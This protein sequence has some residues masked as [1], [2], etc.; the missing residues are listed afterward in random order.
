MLALL[1]ARTHSEPRFGDLGHGTSVAKIIQERK[2][3]CTHVGYCQEK[4]GCQGIVYSVDTSGNQKKHLPAESQVEG[5]SR[6][7]AVELGPEHC[8]VYGK[9]KD[10]HDNRV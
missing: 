5:K 6:I 1:C 4:H 7:T 8:S 10:H 2:G 3:T 9:C